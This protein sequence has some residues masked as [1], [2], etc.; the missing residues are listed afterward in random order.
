M[1][2]PLYQ[3]YVWDE[4]KQVIIENHDHVYEDLDR[5]QKMAQMMADDR[6]SGTVQPRIRVLTFIPKG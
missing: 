5:A 4:L 1:I 3:P 2:G 6:A